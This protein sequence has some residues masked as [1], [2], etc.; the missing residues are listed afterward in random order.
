M[1]DD[2]RNLSGA[3]KK[4]NLG[5]GA[6]LYKGFLN[7]GHWE[8]LI[9]G[10]VYK[11]VNGNVDTFMLNYDLRNGIPAH[12]G[13]LDLVYHCHMLEHLSYKDGIAFTQDC[14]RALAP[15]GKLRIVVPDL[16]L[17]VKAYTTNDRFFFEE[18]R[19]I[20][21]EDIHVTNGAVFMG[22]LH[23]HDHKCGYDFDTI[24]WVLE[25]AGFVNVKKTLYADSEHVDNISEIEPYNPLRVMESLCV[26]CV[27]ALEMAS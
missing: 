12:D 15:G 6:M 9:D 17:W 11:D 16:G 25:H 19:K 22:M 5:C 13:S 10:A 14:Y 26:E 20:L 27:K 21:D 24:K 4:Y 2:L 23:N 18:Y 7:I 8:Q 3:F 1:N